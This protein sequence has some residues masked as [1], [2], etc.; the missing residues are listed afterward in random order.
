MATIDELKAQLALFET[1]NNQMGE[2][3]K[4]T[5]EAFVI[6]QTNFTAMQADV[7]R[8]ETTINTLV[9]NNTLLE[10]KIAFLS[11]TGNPVP[12]AGKETLSRITKTDLLKSM[13]IPAFHSK[14]NFELWAESF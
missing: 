2:S 6:A 7:H 5:Q 9:T 13:E 14:D 10:Q 3:L 11:A 8:H 4:Q 1:Q 12:H